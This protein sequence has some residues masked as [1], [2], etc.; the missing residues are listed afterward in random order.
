M[1]AFL[2]HGGA[3]NGVVKTGIAL[4]A[5]FMAWRSPV[6]LVGVLRG[7]P[8]RYRGTVLSCPVMLGKLL[9]AKLLS[10][11]SGVLPGWVKSSLVLQGKVRSYCG[12]ARSGADGWSTEGRCFVLSGKPLSWSGEVLF[13]CVGRGGVLYGQAKSA[14]LFR[15]IA[16]RCDVKYTRVL[17]AKF[18]LLFWQVGPVQ[19]EVRYSTLLSWRGLGKVKR[20]I[21]KYCRLLFWSGV[22]N[23]CSGMRGVARRT[24]VCYGKFKVLFWSCLAGRSMVLQCPVRQVKLKLLSWWAAA[25]KSPVC[26]SNCMVT[27]RL[28]QYE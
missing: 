27:V 26:Q 15:A 5:T 22:V 3:F 18:K 9:Q 13:C 11:W 4:Q 7:K 23:R 10:W 28:Q 21:V 16:S 19:S 17:L 24:I 2:L 6:G 8:R 12:C 20:C 1:T 14:K 25:L